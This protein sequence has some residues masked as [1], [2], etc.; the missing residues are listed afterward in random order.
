MK[1]KI[2]CRLAGDHPAGSQYNDKITEYID[3]TSLG[4]TEGQWIRLR[5]SEKFKAIEEWWLE[6]SVIIGFE[7][8]GET[9]ER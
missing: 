5:D 2:W 9:R 4:W 8:S 3:V 6:S 1:I 7:E